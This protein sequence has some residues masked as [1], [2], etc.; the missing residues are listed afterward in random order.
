MYATVEQVRKQAT[1]SA[2]NAANI[3]DTARITEDIA[4]ASARLEAET[5]LRFEPHAHTYY[6][7]AQRSDELVL[8]RPLL[9][10][11]GLTLGD[12]VVLTDADFRLHPRGVSPVSSLFP[13]NGYRWGGWTGSRYGA[14]SVEGLWGYHSDYARA[15]TDVATL[16]DALDGANTEVAVSDASG[17]AVGQ[18]V[19]IDD[20]YLRVEAI[21]TNTLTV[22][23]GVN[24]TTA[25]GH[26]A[27]AVVARWNV[28]T[29][30]NRFVVRLAA[31]M[32]ARR[33]A[34]ER[35]TFDGVAT[36]S[37][38][39]DIPKELENLLKTFP[40]YWYIGSV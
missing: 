29:L 22:E 24:G 39:D 19:R 38:P 35:S 17:L 36:V 28:D 16:P 25:A 4:W 14:I 11:T 21:D 30:A 15:W 27:G 34:F 32:L 2:G 40:R 7:D 18:L 5:G 12:G 33:G 8:A 10:V 1:S 6:Y 37:Y 20:E 3:S 31:F 13:L 9:A 23:R 26:D